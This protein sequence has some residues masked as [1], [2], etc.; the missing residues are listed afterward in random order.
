M[1][2][3][4]RLERL[5]H[6]ASSG[7]ASAGAALR[8]IA[9]HERSLR[10]HVPPRVQRTVFDPR[11]DLPER[12]RHLNAE[13]FGVVGQQDRAGEHADLHPAGAG[14]FQDCVSRATARYR[15]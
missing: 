7:S 3:I 15:C 5:K 2:E 14:R 10:L 13:H 6:R 1:S 4:K 9:V 12:R 8:R 11:H